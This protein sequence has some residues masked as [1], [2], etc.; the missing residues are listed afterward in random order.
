VG[1]SQYQLA[2]GSVAGGSDYALTNTGSNQNATVAVPSSGQPA[3][4][5][6]TL[7]SLISGNWQ[8]RSYT[9]TIGASPVPS[10]QGAAASRASEQAFFVYND[11]N[12]RTWPYCLSYPLQVCNDIFDAALISNCVSS[13]N[14]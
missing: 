12:P 14:V 5:Y 4:V 7:R 9:Y 6:A 3:T 1:A 2:L 11:N 8:S 13:D 10:A